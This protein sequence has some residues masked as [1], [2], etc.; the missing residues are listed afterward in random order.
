MGNERVLFVDDEDFLAEWGKEVLLRLG[1]QVT[2]MTDSLEAFKAFS[3]DPSRFDLIITDQT[4]PGMT[5]IQLAAEMLENPGRYSHYA[6][7]RAQRGVV[8]SEDAK[9]MGY[10]GNFS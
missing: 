9:G 4:M 3:A 10:Q 6:L 5:G 1:Y 7:Y 2:S 8:T